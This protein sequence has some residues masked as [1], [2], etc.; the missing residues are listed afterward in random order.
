M[1]PKAVIFKNEGWFQDVT[2]TKPR[3]PNKIFAYLH[4]DIGTIEHYVFCVCIG[5]RR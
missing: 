1:K 4:C 3:D 5:V 2:V